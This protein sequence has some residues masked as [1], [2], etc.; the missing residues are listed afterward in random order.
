MPT[1]HII[2]C[3]HHTVVLLSHFI[4]FCKIVH[5]CFFAFFFSIFVAFILSLLLS[6]LGV[7]SG[8][9]SWICKTSACPVIRFSAAQVPTRLGDEFCSLLIP[10][11]Q[12]TMNCQLKL[13]TRGLVSICSKG[14]RVFLKSGE[15]S[16][17]SE[18]SHSAALYVNSRMHLP[19]LTMWFSAESLSRSGLQSSLN[20]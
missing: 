1:A 6:S 4:L 12:Q 5:P 17:L 20:T 7:C 11:E 15:L 2:F 8:S 10:L 19:F 18:S 14:K 3:L 9:T 16:R 13:V